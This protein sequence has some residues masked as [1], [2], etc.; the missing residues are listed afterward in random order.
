VAMSGFGVYPCVAVRRVSYTGVHHGVTPSFVWI[1]G[2]SDG[3]GF[4]VVTLS[5]A[6]PAAVE[7]PPPES[8][9][10]VAELLQ[11]ASVIPANIAVTIGTASS[12][13]PLRAR[14]STGGAVRIRI[15]LSKVTFNRE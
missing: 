8:E 11:A 12:F 14:R 2:S 3:A 9:T 7:L 1:I 13:R 6:L 5:V 4:K 10:G 15:P